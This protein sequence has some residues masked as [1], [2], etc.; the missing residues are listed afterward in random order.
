MGR[1]KVASTTRES[2]LM[3]FKETKELVNICAP[4]WFVFSSVIFQRYDEHI[5]PVAGVTSAGNHQFQIVDVERQLLRI[6]EGSKRKS[7]IPMYYIKIKCQRLVGQCLACPIGRAVAAPINWY[8]TNTA[9]L[10][11]SISPPQRSCT[12][13]WIHPYNPLGSDVTDADMPALPSTRS[14]PPKAATMS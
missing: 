12:L 3:R 4:C 5:A 11:E 13:G 8:F 10:A 14:E 6:T 2:A 1:N 9:Y 7:T